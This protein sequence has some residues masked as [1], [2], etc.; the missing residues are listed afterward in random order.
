MRKKIIAAVIGTSA[1]SAI[2][3]HD[4]DAATYRVQAGDSLWSIANQFNITIAQLKSYNG[5]TSNLIFP[6]QVLKVS[7]G[8]TSSNTSRVTNTGGSSSGSTYTVRSG[9]TLSSIAARYGTSYTNIMRLNG[10]T[11]TLI[12]PGQTLKVSG[13]ATTPNMGQGAGQAMEDA[14]VLSNVLSQYALP[15]AL[16]RY[17]HLRVKHTAKVTRKSRKIGVM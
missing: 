4:A 6:D 2:A 9:D 13:S 15:E 5:L 7:G 17:D 14:I 10:L 11:S 3:A 8:R 12:Y 16:K 1:V